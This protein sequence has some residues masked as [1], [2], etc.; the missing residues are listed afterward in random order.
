MGRSGLAEPSWE[1]QVDGY[2]LHVGLN[3]V[4]ETVYGWKGELKGCEAD[5]R[6]MYEVAGHA[7][8]ASSTILIGPQATAQAVLD[9]LSVA[10]NLAQPGD[11]FLLTFAGHGGQV[12]DQDGDETGDHLDETWVLYDRMLLDDEL[13]LAFTAFAPGVRILVVADCCH[14]GIDGERVIPAEASSRHLAA[15]LPT[16]RGVQLAAQHAGPQ[17]SVLSLAA[18]KENQEAAD[19]QKNGRFTAA[20]LSVWNK[21]GFDGDYLAFHGAIAEKLPRK[22]Q[23]DLRVSG[24]GDVDAFRQQRPFTVV[25]P[26]HWFGVDDAQGSAVQVSPDGSMTVTVTVQIS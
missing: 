17:A 20:L 8:F 24:G 22:Q 16:Y 3:A 26:Q 9:Q 19:G 10:A 21:N 23:P 4:D 2:S 7:G 18:A 12:P 13:Q 1:D 25:A 14:S 15:M 11:L 6:S 5:A